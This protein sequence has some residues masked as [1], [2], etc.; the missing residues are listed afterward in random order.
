MTSLGIPQIPAFDQD[1]AKHALLHQDQLTKPPKS[2]GRLEELA[3]FYAG[4][5]GCFPVPTPKHAFLPVFGA[6]HGVTVEGVS[7]FPAHLTA[8]ILQNVVNGG[9]A[10]SVLGR[11]HQVDLLAVDVGLTGDLVGSPQ[12]RI[13][14]LNAKVRRGTRNLR[15]ED[16]MTQGEAIRAIEVGIDVALQRVTGGVDI[17]GMGEVG[18]G[19]TTASAALIAAFTG[20]APARVT[21]TGTGVTTDGLQKKITV[22]TDAIHRLGQRRDPL[23]VAAALGGLEIL[24]MAGFLLKC[25]SLRVPV[26]LDGVIASAAALL[27]QGL[28]PASTAFLIASHRSTEPGIVAAQQLLGLRPLFDLEMRLGEG[29]GAVIGIALVRSAV[30]LANEMDSFASAGLL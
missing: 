15:V 28:C 23:D 5:R 8:P 17:V 2:L 21:G 24:A 1:A 25:A 7:A 29:T 26:V 20:E 16:A 12:S 13:P 18:I 30:A 11:Q 14:A 10:I 6:D 3:V 22:V 19:N 9:A 4:A 27:A